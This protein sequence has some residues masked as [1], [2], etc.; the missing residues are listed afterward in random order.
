MRKDHL[1]FSDLGAG[2]GVDFRADSQAEFGKILEL[3]WGPILGSDFG[4]RFWGTIFGAYFGDFATIWCRFSS[5]S[6]WYFKRK[7]EGAL[8]G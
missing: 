2:L 6:P 5:P 8:S 1:T 4:V 3:I 7:S